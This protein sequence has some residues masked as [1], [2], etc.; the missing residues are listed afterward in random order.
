MKRLYVPYKTRIYYSDLDLQAA[1]IY[2]NCHAA[3]LT[4]TEQ[5]NV[6]LTQDATNQAIPKKSQQGIGGLRIYF[7]GRKTLEF[8]DLFTFRNS[9]ENKF[10]PFCCVIENSICKKFNWALFQKKTKQGFLK[11]PEI[12]SQVFYFTP[13]NSPQNFTTP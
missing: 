4:S 12:F 8:L 3:F 1:S 11:T 10:S 13:G 6:K 9:R 5:L 2:S 7:S